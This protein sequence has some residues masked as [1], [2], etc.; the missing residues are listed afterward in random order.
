MSIKYH[1]DLIFRDFDDA[2]RNFSTDSTQFKTALKTALACLTAVLIANAVK[3]PHPYWSGIT[4]LVIMRTHVGTSF[5][6]G[7]M[8]TAGCTLGCMLGF[9]F[10]AFIVQNPYLFSLFIFLGMFLAFYA[11]VRANNSYFWSYM[12]ANMV[13]IGLMSHANPYDNFPL[14]IAY[15]RALEIFLGVMCSWL[16]NIIIWPNYASDDFER[17]FTGIISAIDFF[18]KELLRQCLRGE[19]SLSDLKELRD[20]IEK[21]IKYCKSL[22]E[23]VGIESK[24][25]ICDAANHSMIFK[26]VQNRVSS[27]DKLL[28]IYANCDISEIPGIFKKLFRR[29]LTFLNSFPDFGLFF[30]RNFKVPQANP[31]YMQDFLDR[32]RERIQPLKV[33]SSSSFFLYSLILYL[34]LSFRDIIDIA[35]RDNQ[36]AAES[37]NPS[38]KLKIK[39][40]DFL[41]LVLFNNRFSFY[42]PSIINA[43]KGGLIVVLIFWFCVWLQ[44]PG[45]YLNMT[46]A[47]LAVMGPQLSAMDTK[48]KGILRFSGCIAGGIIG[49]FLLLCA[50]DSTLLNFFWFFIVILFFAYIWGAKPGVAYIGLQGGI[51]FLLCSAGDFYPVTSFDSIFERLAGIF[52]AVIIMWVMNS[53]IWPDD[54]I[55]RLF[56]KIGYLHKA[57]NEYVSMFLSKQKNFPEYKDHICKS[58]SVYLS[59]TEILIKNCRSQDYAMNENIDSIHE[60]ILKL[61]YLFSKLLILEKTDSE[62]IFPFK[63]YPLKVTKFLMRIVRFSIHENMDLQTRR[64]ISLLIYKEAVQMEKI[65]EKIINSENFLISSAIAKFEL[66]R[67]F[68]RV[69]DILQKLKSLNAIEFTKPL[70]L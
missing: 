35:R 19:K 29:T 46:V 66:C 22:I 11:G 47:I 68:I 65:K 6:K 12:L 45:G 24:I 69:E 3:L 34:E 4:V 20:N 33:S 57:I 21:D 50:I 43:V 10:F 32:N 52:I 60:Y 42:I 9:F 41:Y 56:R 31:S 64:R 54:F 58:I 36:L 62:L 16:Y 44:V 28:E 26:R 38:R 48:H 7:W 30:T 40:S 1:Y 13:L 37:E 27:I 51:A 70:I 59:E 23:P 25:S 53:I 63:I 17:K 5:S 2:V 15:E 39:H 18:N 67:F 14:F 49:L 55:S 61:N 8:R